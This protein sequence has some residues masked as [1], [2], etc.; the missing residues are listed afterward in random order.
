[1][2]GVVPWI[3][4]CTHGANIWCFVVSPNQ[5]RWLLVKSSP[6]E[7][8]KES[9]SQRSGW[10]FFP[11]NTHRPTFF[12]PSDRRSLSTDLGIA[13]RG[14][15]QGGDLLLPEGIA[16]EALPSGNGNG[17]EPLSDVERWYRTTSDSACCSRRL[18]LDVVTDQFQTLVWSKLC[19]LNTSSSTFWNVFCESLKSIPYE[20]KYNFDAN[21]PHSMIEKS[22]S[23]LI[24]EVH[25]YFVLLLLLFFF[26][27]DVKIIPQETV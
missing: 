26:L 6:S 15:A 27:R 21:E 14:Q 13:I 2:V 24:V 23:N 7:L 18:T 11:S 17:L 5:A 20:D 22:D 10:P 4:H 3:R 8:P 12:I 9:R 19:L 25:C 16:I 1:M